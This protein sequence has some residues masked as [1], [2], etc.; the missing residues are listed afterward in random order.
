MPERAAFIKTIG[1][2]ELFRAICEGYNVSCVNVL[3]GF[4]YFAEK[5]RVWEEQPLSPHFIF[6]G[7]ESFGYLLGT[8]TRDKDAITASLLIC[9]AALQAKLEGK[10]L[11]DRLHNLYKTYGFYLEKLVTIDCGESLEG[12]EKM[13][14][15]MEKLQK[16]PPKTIC[17][18]PVDSIE[19]YSQSLKLETG[20]PLPF[21]KSN[22]LLFWLHDGSK[23]MI[24][25]SG[26][27]PKIKI[28]CGVMQREWKDLEEVKKSCEK[29]AEALTEALKD[30][31]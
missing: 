14:Q 6:G 15:G 13:K 16:N 7:E 31:F 10:T 29:R 22:V 4:K 24:R 25:P 28:Y 21:P 27:E 3:T 18:I 2:T 23:L 17:N 9:E 26:T 1:T 20:E 8:L 19:D 12:K 5:I 30:L 11:I